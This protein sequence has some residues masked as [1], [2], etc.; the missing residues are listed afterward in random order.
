[1]VRTQLVCIAQ[2]WVSVKLFG[3]K[4]IHGWKRGKV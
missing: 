4:N 1:M 3:A 2:N